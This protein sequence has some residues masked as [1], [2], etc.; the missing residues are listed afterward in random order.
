[1][2]TL[3]EIGT[4]RWSK[5]T[6]G[7]LSRSEREGLLKQA[8]G[9]QELA[10]Q[11]S[12]LADFRATKDGLARIDS[13]KIRIPDSRTAR[14]AE[15]L[16][17]ELGQT[18]LVNHCYRTYWWGSLLAQHDAILIED[19]EAFYV[20]SLL[21]DLGLTE[22]HFCCNTE[23]HCFAVEGALAAD[24]FLETQGWELVRRDVVAEAITLHLNMMVELAHG[25]LAH[26]LSAGAKCDVVGARSTDISSAEIEKV[27]RR[28]P[29]L[30]F[31]DE[32]ATL[33]GAEAEIRPHGRIG[34]VL[35]NFSLG[36]LFPL[37]KLTSS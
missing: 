27:L 21:H 16:M 3:E 1:M 31:A 34:F 37:G 19:E 4:L 12:S 29:G 30:R 5:R 26:Y 15:Q 20:A 25:P 22:K 17:E 28:Y 32:F 18:S 6:G 14:G 35:S 23:A 33:L 11:S 36:E 2:T 9:A 8:L 24:E 10:V 7:Q 13:G